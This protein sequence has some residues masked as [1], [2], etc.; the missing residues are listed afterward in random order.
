MIDIASVLRKLDDTYDEG[1]QEVK[2][3]GL[4]FITADG[5]LRTMVCRKNVKNPGRGSKKPTRSASFNL[6]R[7]GTM[8]VT[9]GSQ[10]RHVKPATICGFRDHNSTVWLPVFH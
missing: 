3:Y 10:P 7:A 6:K 1:T 5:R 4:R 9:E 2:E 8:L